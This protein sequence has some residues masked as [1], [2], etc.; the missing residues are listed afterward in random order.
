MTDI[1]DAI[2][3]KL[4]VQD[5]YT[6]P[7]MAAAIAAIPT[8]GGVDVEALSVT[9]N[10]TYTAPTGKA[11]SPVTVNVPSQGSPLIVQ[12]LKYL[13]YSH[14]YVAVGQEYYYADPI[15]TVA[16][17]ELEVGAHY[18]VSLNGSPGPRFRMVMFDNEPFTV[19]PPNP[20]AP[21][22]GQQVVMQNGI[23]VGSGYTE[24]PPAYTNFAFEATKRYLGLHLSLTPG[25]TPTVYLFKII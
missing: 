6:P 3:T 25:D 18:I 2:R 24:N 1:A 14:Y 23:D 17:Y 20:P 5:T 10:G 21:G 16:S 11:Y 19:I 22:S 13:T 15:E 9:A 4:G 7:Q 12:P 8:G